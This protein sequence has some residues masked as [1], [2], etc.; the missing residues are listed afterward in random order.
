M[1]VITQTIDRIVRCVERLDSVSDSLDRLRQEISQDKIDK[2]L[3]PF[4]KRHG[5]SAPVS[6]GPLL[7]TITLLEH[8]CMELEEKMRFFEQDTPEP[9]STERTTARPR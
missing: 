8:T 2:D 1:S 7:A 9:D 3:I 4:E 6:T 5:A